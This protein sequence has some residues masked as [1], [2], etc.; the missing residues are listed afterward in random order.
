MLQKNAFF[1]VF[2]MEKAYF[3]IIIEENYNKKVE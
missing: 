2:S 3:C 1:L